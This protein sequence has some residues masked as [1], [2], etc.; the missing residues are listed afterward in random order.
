MGERWIMHTN[1]VEEWKATLSQIRSDLRRR[2]LETFQR[3]SHVFRQVWV[4]LQ[5]LHKS[6]SVRLAWVHTA[7]VYDEWLH[8]NRI[9]ISRK[10]LHIRR[11]VIVWNWIFSNYEE[12][13]RSVNR[14][15]NWCQPQFLFILMVMKITVSKPGENFL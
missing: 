6:L 11:A 14:Q 3:I 1:L 7:E 12:I 4:V 13:F 2:G 8:D 10:Q 9:L 5:P 15:P